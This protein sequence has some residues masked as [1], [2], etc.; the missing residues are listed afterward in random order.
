MEIAIPLIALGGMYVISNQN[1]KSCNIPPPPINNKKKEN[2][3]NMGKPVNYLPNTD[4][5]PQNYPV[6]N[7]NQVLDSRFTWLFKTDEYKGDDLYNIFLKKV[8]EIGWELHDKSNIDAKWFIKNKEYFKFYGRDIET[9]L[10]KTKIAHSKRV[11]CKPNYEKK[12]LI[13]SDLDN[14]F[15]IYLK[16]NDIKTKKDSEKIK[17]EI[18][19]SLYC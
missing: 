7:I 14:G 3:T 4:L 16:N 15:E 2:F 19:N 17:K 9:I 13:L 12:K 8:N 1:N 5:I 18:Y 6:S 10:S 11:Y